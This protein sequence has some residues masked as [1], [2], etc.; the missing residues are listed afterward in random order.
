MLQSEM[1]EISYQVAELEKENLKLK[2]QVC[3]LYAALEKEPERK[4]KHC[5][6]C[7]HFVKHYVRR[8][9]GNFTETH[10]GHCTH[11][12]MKSRKQDDTC[13]YFS[14]GNI[15]MKYL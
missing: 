1:K 8:E 14:F 15:E 10:L 7:M 6:Q 5:H 12:I 11:G 3:L 9:N 2:E 4:P 13:K